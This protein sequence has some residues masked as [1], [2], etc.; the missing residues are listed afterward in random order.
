MS[1]LRCRD[2]TFCSCSAGVLGRGNLAFAGCVVCSG[3]AT[4]AALPDGLLTVLG[5]W[6]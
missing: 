6:A 1:R 2:V 4:L 3:I 5:A